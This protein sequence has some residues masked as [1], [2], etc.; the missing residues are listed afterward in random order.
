MFIWDNEWINNNID[1]INEFFGTEFKT[2]TKEDRQRIAIALDCYNT[3]EEFNNALD[4]L[5]LRKEYGFELLSNEGYATLI[6]G[7]YIYFNELNYDMN[8]SL[9][10]LIA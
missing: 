3:E 10:D 1:K 2:E 9:D 8:K 5:Y 7:V 4:G 6:D